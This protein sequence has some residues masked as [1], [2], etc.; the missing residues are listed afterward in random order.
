LQGAD[1]RR[2]WVAIIGD[3]ASQ[4]SREGELFFVGKVKVRHG[5]AARPDEPAGA[6]RAGD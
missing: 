2:Q 3:R 1:A 4:L 5:A 6:M